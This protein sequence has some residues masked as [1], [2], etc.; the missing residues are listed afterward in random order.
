MSLGRKLV[1]PDLI[2]TCPFQWS[3]HPDYERAR[4]ESAAWVESFGV[5]TDRKG[6]VF[7]VSNFELLMA[8]TYPDAG[9]EEVRT[10]CDCINIVFFVR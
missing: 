6:I 4:A 9:Y 3:V 5:F 8:L 10:C 7:N 2:S 1:L